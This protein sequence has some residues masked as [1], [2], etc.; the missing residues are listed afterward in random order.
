MLLSY[1]IFLLNL[2]RWKM[3]SFLDSWANMA[4]GLLLS[5]WIQS[6][7]CIVWP[8]R[9]ILFG[10]VPSSWKPLPPVLPK[11]LQIGSIIVTNLAENGILVLMYK[12]SVL[13]TMNHKLPRCLIQLLKMSLLILPLMSTRIWESLALLTC[14]MVLITSQRMWRNQTR[15]GWR[16]RG[17]SLQ[18]ICYML[19]LQK[20]GGVLCYCYPS[21]W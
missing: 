16:D 18:F 11:S 9:W 17:C 15:S 14:H 13:Y 1:G 4:R 10:L 5:E 7:L 19:C 21:W 6:Q 20:G 12:E 3:F 8:E 2:Q